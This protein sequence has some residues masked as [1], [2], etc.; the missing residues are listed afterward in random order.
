MSIPAK[1]E[2]LLEAQNV[3]YQ[4]AQADIASPLLREQHLKETGAAKLV[5]LQDD[6]G[7]LQAIIPGDHML[8]LQK[9]NRLTKRNFQAATPSTTDQFCQK[10]AVN[11]LPALPQLTGLPAVVEKAL[12]ARPEILIE[13]GADGALLTLSQESFKQILTDGNC[14]SGTFSVPVSQIQAAADSLESDVGQITDAVHTF[15]S[16]RVKQRLDEVLDFPP[17][18]DTAKR[19]IELRVDPYADINDLSAIVEMDPSLAAQVVSWAASPYYAAPGKIKSVHD[20]IVRVLGFDLVLNL[21]LGLAL[22]KTLTLPKDGPNGYTPFWQQ[23]V[24]GAATVEALIKAIPAEH[25]PSL[26]MAYLSGLLH[27]FG[28]LILAEIFPPQFALCCRHAEVN[29]HINHYEI[30]QYLLGITRD[31]LASL[32]MGKW[33]LPEEVCLALRFQNNPGYTGPHHQF[34]KVLNISTHLLRQRGIGDGSLDQPAPGLFKDLHLDPER[35]EDVIGNVIASSDEL[36]TI[37]KE[38]AA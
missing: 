30:E 14:Q 4:L 33:Q 15:T 5:M 32:L 13:S 21:T 16:L 35:A 11:S 38:L 12:L 26:G 20:A 7:R 9:L 31:Q 29:P 23:S 28:Y 36:I 19:I 6:Q 27:N 22:G 3:S 2:Q 24:F 8:D 25:R 18:P 1:I 17:L 37:A 10:L 34:A